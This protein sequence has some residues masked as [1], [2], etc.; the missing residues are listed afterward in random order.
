VCNRPI[1]GP[2]EI[3]GEDPPYNVRYRFINPEHPQPVT[4]GGFAW[5]R[6][7]ATVNN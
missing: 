5:V 2:V 1:P 6:V 3:F 7:R 4:F